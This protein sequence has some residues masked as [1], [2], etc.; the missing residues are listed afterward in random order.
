MRNQQDPPSRLAHLYEKNREKEIAAQEIFGPSDHQLEESIGSF[1]GTAASIGVGLA[2][3]SA[4]WKLGGPVGS[5]MGGNAG[6]RMGEKIG[7]AVG[8]SAG[9][10]IGSLAVGSIAYTLFHS[11]ISKTGREPSKE[12]LIYELERKLDA[13]EQQ[14]N[15]NYSDDRAGSYSGGANEKMLEQMR[16]L[17]DEISTVR[18]LRES[19]G[20]YDWGYDEEDFQE[21]IPGQLLGAG[22]RLAGRFAVAGLK[23]LGNAAVSGVKSGFRAV[24]R[25]VANAAV[26]DAKSLVAATKGGVTGTVSK[27]GQSIKN[28]FSKKPGVSA[29]DKKIADLA[30]FKDVTPDAPKKSLLGKIGSGLGQAAN[31]AFNPSQVV[32]DKLAKSANPLAQKAANVFSSQAQDSAMKTFYKPKSFGKLVTGSAADTIMQTGAL[33]GA[34]AAASRLRKF[35]SREQ[36]EA[37]TDTS[38][39]DVANNAKVARTAA[40]N[41]KSLVGG[42][43]RRT[44]ARTATLGAVKAAGIKI[45][46]IGM[47]GKEQSV[48]KPIS[49]TRPGQ[50]RD[51]DGD[52]VLNEEENGSQGSA[53]QSSVGAAKPFKPNLTK[54]K[55]K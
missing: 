38:A 48:G 50:P 46:S 20:E 49:A 2:A 12:Q 36:S 30:S 37:D 17:S 53:N 51:G 15:R 29:V 39:G 22:G 7:R 6:K 35:G 3:A 26:A 23:K 1:L 42:D 4:G 28:A 5:N 52:G 34:G 21:G 43:I 40:M 16:Q 54:T 32:G 44:A 11:L 24:T 55:K 10:L 9:S 45:P 27:V 31:V 41:A 33:A 19:S 18:S 47:G 14:V 13:L 8:S 25:P